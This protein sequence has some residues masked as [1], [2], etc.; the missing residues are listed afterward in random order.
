MPIKTR[1]KESTFN[2]LFYFMDDFKLILKKPTM[3]RHRCI[4]TQEIYSDKAS[5]NFLFILVH[6]F[7]FIYTINSD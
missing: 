2:S 7:I 4:K 1:Y 5:N 3:D 6:D